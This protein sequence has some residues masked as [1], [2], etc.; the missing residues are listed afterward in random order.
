MAH[1]GGSV[2]G[3]AIFDSDRKSQYTSADFKTFTD[4]HDIHLS[5]GDVEVCWDNAVTKSFF[6]ILKP[7]ILYE[8]KQ[9]DSKLETHVSLKEGIKTYH[10]P[11]RTNSLT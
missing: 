2:A 4:A 7:H 8:R 9:F 11:R 3:D 1:S 5:V 6:P 10:N